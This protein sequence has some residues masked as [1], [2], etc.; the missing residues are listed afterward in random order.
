MVIERWTGPP[1]DTHTYLVIDDS[2]Q[3]AWAVDAPL[4]TF[5]HVSAFVRKESVALERLILTHGHFDHLL[6]AERYQSAG[7][8][9]SA[10]PKDRALMETPQAQLFGLPHRM[11]RVQIAEELAEGQTLRLG[12]TEWQV[13]HTPGHSPGHVVLYSESQRTLLG[14]DM[15]FRGG[16]GRVD[17]PGSDAGE[18]AVSLLRLLELPD[19]VRVLPG[20]GP[21]T[22]V[23][24][25]RA[26]LEELLSH[27]RVAL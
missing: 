5:G 6:D 14:G 9:V 21:E 1:V 8:P 22:T 17:L 16:Y 3:V 7:V 4:E 12:A 13:W 25:E 15:L 18:M 26:W 27:P 2:A 11:P 10:N 24:A 23:G 20:H 19:D